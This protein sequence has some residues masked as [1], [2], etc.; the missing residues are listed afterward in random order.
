VLAKSGPDDVIEININSP[1]GMVDTAIAI[2]EAMR[3]SQATIVTHVDGVAASAAS[4][5]LLCG[6]YIYC[7]PHAEIMIHSGTTGYFGEPE[8][9]RKEA[10]FYEGRLA[11]IM[12]DY[13]SKFFTDEEIDEV[14]EGKDLYLTGE[15]MNERLRNACKEGEEVGDE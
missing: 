8:K 12:K 6:E 2:C 9:I 5:I 11:G 3:N 14:I 7:G 4:L 1:G 13:Y 10:K 15:D